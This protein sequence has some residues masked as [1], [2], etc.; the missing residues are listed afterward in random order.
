MSE[1]F[2]DGVRWGT[3]TPDY[4][5]AI[6]DLSMPVLHPIFAHVSECDSECWNYP[7]GG[8]VAWAK[9][10]LE[11]YEPWEAT[12]EP[13]PGRDWVDCYC[14]IA[15]CQMILASPEVFADLHEAPERT[16][17][18]DSPPATAS[19]KEENPT[20]QKGGDE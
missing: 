20:T 5:G 13:I 16:P 7:G 9:G 6:G 10:I 12:R 3:L 14:L 18:S 19:A 15:G 8:P 4:V 1:C 11:D 2:D 17:L